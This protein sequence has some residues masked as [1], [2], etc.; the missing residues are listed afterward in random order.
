MP[1]SG[2]QPRDPA[3]QTQKTGTAKLAGQVTSLETGRPIRRAVVRAFGP[4]LRVGKSVSTDAEGRWELSELPAG[5]FTISLTKGG[6]VSLSDGQQRPFE[7][8]KTIDVAEVRWSG[9]WTCH[10]RA[11]ARSPAG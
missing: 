3:A 6:E 11:A 10:S 8:G 7:A 1:I 9:S 2:G 5:R 4:E